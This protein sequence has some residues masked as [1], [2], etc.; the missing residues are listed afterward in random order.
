M[1]SSAQMA[2]GRREY[3]LRTGQR[4]LYLFLAVIFI[5]MAVLFFA[6][7]HSGPV[8]LPTMF[9]P[10]M[11]GVAGLYLALVALR[12]KLVTDGTRVT[13]QGA[14][15][16]QEFDMNQVE[17]YRTFRNRYQSYQV[18]CLNG[19]GTISLMK[20]GAGMDEW[21]AGLKDLDAQDRDQLLEKIDQDQELG[22]TPE[23]RRGALASAK[24]L[25]FAVCAVD[26]A[27]V[28]ALIW[29]PVPYR[30]MAM[31]VAALAPAAAA[32]IL[33]KQPLLYAMFRTRRDPR[34]DVNLVLIIS[35]FGLLFSAIDVNFISPAQ[36]L[37]FFAVGTI[38]S[39]ALFYSA[40]RKNPRFAATL[41][42]LCVLSALYGWGLAASADTVADRSVSRTYTAQVLGGHV[43]RGSRSTTYYLELAPWG[44][45]AAVD[46]QM[47]V[48]AGT[49]AATRPG[50][51]ICLALHAGAL[52]S[53]WY[54]MVPCQ[55]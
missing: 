17:G 53:P 30:L 35:G 16:T 20:Y 49:Y 36:L 27:A 24:R 28:A 2:M 46:M 7:N 12:S 55:H 19:G 29:G 39:L 37:P 21:L 47:K 1:A 13:V 4:A 23:E 5:G 22:A 44:P 8:T 26:V 31:T 48:S 6:A 15:R 54:E 52:H 34:A 38:A 11:F 25:T 32:Y 41:V 33:Y 50:Q 45:D 3:P 40:A 14:M 9:A 18:I 42:G 51:V 43:S 10:A